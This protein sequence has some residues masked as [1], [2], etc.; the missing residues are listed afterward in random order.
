MY[1]VWCMMCD[2]WCMMYDVWCMMYDVWCM[3]YDVWCIMYDVWSQIFERA[4]YLIPY[5]K[6]LTSFMKG[7]WSTTRVVSLCKCVMYENCWMCLM[8]FRRRE[9]LHKHTGNEEGA[10]DRLLR[11]FE[12]NS[13][14]CTQT[15]TYTHT[16]THTHIYIYIYIYIHTHTPGCIVSTHWHV[17]DY[18]TYRVYRPWVSSFE[19][20]QCPW[21]RTVQIWHWLRDPHM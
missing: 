10:G 9:S 15:H 12:P 19:T 5:R 3:M 8:L 1:D 4:V 7:L 21:V 17:I 14:V 13:N 11:R 6:R 16:H 20:D 2:V 18:W